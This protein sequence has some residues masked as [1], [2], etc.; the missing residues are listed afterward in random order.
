MKKSSYFIALLILL[1]TLFGTT[2]VGALSVSQNLNI[3]FRNRTANPI[4]MN[5]TTED[6]IKHWATIPV[7]VSR[8]ELPAGNLSYWANTSCGN[9]SGR[10]NLSDA[11]QT[12]VFDCENAQAQ[13]SHAKLTSCDYGFFARLGDVGTGVVFL[14]KAKWE[15]PSNPYQELV[16][17]LIPQIPLL[18][19]W[20]SFGCEN[21][22]PYD[23][24]LTHP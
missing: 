17:G 5:Y 13:I 23:S 9:L 4:A 22:R 12:I 19:G 2:S 21:S 7:G 1:A 10:L 3:P 18:N 11:T 14:S 6:G 8:V 15:D 16:D 24:Y 20:Y